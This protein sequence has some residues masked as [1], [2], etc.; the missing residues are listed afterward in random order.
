[1]KVKPSM[2]YQIDSQGKHR[3]HIACKKKVSEVPL[4][5]CKHTFSHRVVDCH[6]DLSP[7]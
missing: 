1:M 2:T 4:D 5:N 3:V 6:R 7:R